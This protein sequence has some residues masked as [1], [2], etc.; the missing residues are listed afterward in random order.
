MPEGYETG[1]KVVILGGGVAGL[2]AAQELIERGFEVEVY[3]KRRI[4]G[5]K[6]RSMDVEGTG[7]GGRQPL[8]GEHGF[9]FFPSFYRHLFDT[10]RRIPYGDNTNGVFDNLVPTEHWMIAREGRSEISL[11][12][13]LPDAIEDWRHIFNVF[14]DDALGVPDEESRFFIDRILAFMTSCEERRDEQFD[15]ID[16]WEYLDAGE[17]S[18]AYQQ[19]HAI[20]LTRGL[21]AMRARDSS[22]RTVGKIYVQMLLGL[23][24]PWLEVDSVLDGPTNEVWIDPWVEHLRQKGVE[25]H[26]ET[27]VESIDCRDG[28]ITGVQ[29]RAGTGEGDSGTR[30]VHADYYIAALPVEV[31]RELSDE[32]MLEAAPSLRG[33]DE[34]RTEWMNGCQFYLDEDAE[35]NPG[36]VIYYDS[37]WALTSISQR[38]FWDADEYDFSNFGDGTVDG[39]LSVCI[40]DWTRDGEIVGKP[41][42]ECT[43]E[44]IRREVWGE[45]TA[46]LNDDRQTNLTEE[47][48]VHFHLDPDIQFDDDTVTNSEPLLV[49]TKGSLQHRPEADLAI[50][51]LFL[52]SDY[53]RT[54]VDLASMEAANEAARRAVNA[55]L[56]DASLLDEAVDPCEI[57]PLEEP[58]IF[59]PMKAY[60]RL[61]W[62]FGRSHQNLPADLGAGDD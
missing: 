22:T 27:T 41:A 33:L 57:W 8:P 49:N 53:V 36:H 30:E 34:L 10:M 46:R 55:I 37:P 58:D 7:G 28:R 1:K 44:E 45:I 43:R 4:W 2:S 39:I 15:H 17:K 21:V 20:G 61:R 13:Q 60:D 18:E 59:E 26:P 6:A 14:F 47:N 23:A 24:A 40:S 11:P 52:A 48:V 51:N 32:R 16:W 12:L 54:H 38:Q 5:G 9:R 3:E 56:E 42:N 50:P 31:M 29:L 35:V 19:A 62:E 25:L